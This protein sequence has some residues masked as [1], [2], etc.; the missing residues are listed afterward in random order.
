MSPVKMNVKSPALAKRSWYICFVFFEGDRVYFFQGL[1]LFSS[2][3][4]CISRLE[5]LDYTRLLGGPCDYL[6]Y[7]YFFNL[8]VKLLLVKVRFRDIKMDH[9]HQGF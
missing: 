5:L 2:G 4:G 1:G 8:M 9:L 6:V 7:F 3:D